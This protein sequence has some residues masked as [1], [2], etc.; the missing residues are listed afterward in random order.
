MRI[1]RFAWIGLTLGLAACAADV[2][3]RGVAE[4]FYSQQT[5][6]G[7]RRAVRWNSGSARYRSALADALDNS[8]LQGDVR[9]AVRLSETAT[10]LAPLDARG[11]ARLGAAYEAAGLLTHAGRAYRMAVALFPRS[12]ELNW[13]L[14][15]FLLRQDDVADGLAAFGKAVA[16]AP[17]MRRAAYQTAWGAT[18][19]SREILEGM[20]PA[21][22]EILLDYLHYLLETQR[23]EAAGEVWWRMLDGGFP[24]ATGEALRYV[25]ATLAGGRTE[26]AIAAWEA[27]SIRAPNVYATHHRTGNRVTNGGFEFD[28]LDGGLD[29][30]I[31]SVGGAVARVVAGGAAE[32]ARCLEVVFAGTHNV[33]YGQVFQFVPVAAATR[34]RFTVRVRTRGITSDSGPQFLLRDARDDRLLRVATTP[35]P[36]TT[37]WTE[38]RVEFRT[39]PATR[40][41]ELRLIRPASRKFSG[42]IS[43]T[44]WVDDVRVTAIDSVAGAAN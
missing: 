22:P 11:W 36:G 34:Y 12:P 8:P 42:N 13:R 27:L 23:L 25:D 38:L 39:S 10:Q 18:D 4:W 24:M 7:M 2:A 37:D 16:G 35:V 41:I 5:I 14:G 32:G 15:N 6:E 19:H 17:G 30:R 44:L 29:W 33:E 40:L 3:R 1:V 9:E 26:E 43:G 21:Q 28:A 20:I 31:T